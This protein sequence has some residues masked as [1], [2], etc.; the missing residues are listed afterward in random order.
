MPSLSGSLRTQAS[1][2]NNNHS[3]LS[4]STKT[5]PPQPTGARELEQRLKQKQ[6]KALTF[7]HAPVLSAEDETSVTA[8]IPGESVK[9]ML[10]KDNDGQIIMVSCLEKTTWNL[11]YMIDLLKLASPVSVLPTE[12]YYEVF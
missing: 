2:N 7:H 11:G 6:I 5:N 9:T 12:D 1:N 4:S 3:S 10:I 8:Y